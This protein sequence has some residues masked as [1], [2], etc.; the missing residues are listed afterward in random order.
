MVEITVRAGSGIV[1]N[2]DFRTPTISRGNREGD[3][4]TDSD[5]RSKKTGQEQLGLIAK[6]ADSCFPP[7]LDTRHTFTTD[8]NGRHEEAPPLPSAGILAARLCGLSLAVNEEKQ[9]SK[10][11]DE[12]LG[13]QKSISLH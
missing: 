5:T 6:L 12:W 13:V 8:W 11:P 3:L 4:V 9:A 2:Q 10:T 7:Q 1:D